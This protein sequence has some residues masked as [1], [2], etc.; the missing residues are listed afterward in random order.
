MEA[1]LY[2]VRQIGEGF[3][4]VMARP[5]SGE[6]IDDEFASIGRAGVR[7]VVSL[8]EASEAYELGLQEEGSCCER[9]GLE[10]RSFPITDRAVPTSV[11]DFAHATRSVYESVVGGE[12]TVVHCRAGI[13]RTG[14]FAAGVLLHGACIEPSEA[15]DLVASARGTEVPDT[16]EQREWLETHAKRIAGST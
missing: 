11:G 2:V 10:F 12:S 5:V 1:R 15:F 6:W 7:T 16:L 3:L 9:A 4:A 14:L 13:G 8:L